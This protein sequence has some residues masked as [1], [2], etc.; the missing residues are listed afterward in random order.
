MFDQ[1]GDAFLADFGIARL[2]EGAETL[3]GENVIGTPAY[4][5]PEQIHGDQTIDGRSDIYALGVICFEMLT[6]RRPYQ[7]KT[8]AKLMMQHLIDPV[9]DIRE[10]NPDLPP[11]VEEVI[12]RSMAKAPEER[13][14]DAGEMTGTLESLASID[15]QTATAAKMAAAA[16][17]AGDAVP[18][19]PEAAP[20]AVKTDDNEVDVTVPDSA[21]MIAPDR[22]PEAVPLFEQAP[23]GETKGKDGRNKWIIPAA[24]LSAILLIAIIAALFFRDSFS[25]DEGDTVVNAEPPFEVES[26]VEEDGSIAAAEDTAPPEQAVESDDT[27]SAGRETEADAQMERFFAAMDA[28]DY[29]TAEQ[30][31]NQAIELFPEEAWLYAER[32]WLREVTGDLEGAVREITRAIELDPQNGDFYAARGNV[33]R[34]LEEYT[35]ALAHHIRAVELSPENPYNHMELAETYKQLEDPGMALEHYNQ[36]LALKEDDAWFYDARANIYAELGD[37]D[38]ALADLERAAELEPEQ[39]DFF[40]RAGDMFLYEAEDP[41]RA[42]DSYN[43]AVERA[44]DDGWAYADRAAAYEAMGDIGAALDDLNHAVELDAENSTF[45]IR[46]GLLYLYELEDHDAAL[47]DLNMAVEIDPENADAYAE[48]ANFFQTYAGDLEAALEDRNT[49]VALDPEG[50]WRYAD[51]FHVYREMGRDDEALADLHRCL[52]LDPDY[53]WC[54][55]ERAWV[56]D[57]FGQR[58]DAVTDFQQFLDTSPEDDCPECHDEASRYIEENS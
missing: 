17:A 46:R 28:E 49:A 7:E 36:A 18:P 8:P 21:E 41:Q 39:R 24:I 47:A 52:D 55:W 12:S 14:S 16:K 29:V 37:Y 27:G 32:G 43:M 53:Y 15:P 25:P 57:S 51:R 38:M 11:G 45:F 40:T 19:K 3:T 30:A 56:Y 33:H 31:I 2:T 5:S 22:A 6:G 9:P 42:L 10:V 4:M 54:A 44:P 23:D 58:L 48:R 20:Q 13:Y 26:P 35:A 1:Y 34:Q 50:P